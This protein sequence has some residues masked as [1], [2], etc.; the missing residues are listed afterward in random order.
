MDYSLFAAVLQGVRGGRVLSV[1]SSP[2]A[3]ALTRVL[4]GDAGMPVC[5]WSSQ[6]SSAHARLG[7]LFAAAV[8]L[9]SPSFVLTFFN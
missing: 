6:E 9:L 8:P 7:R 5:G 3:P 1:L 2:S 4:L